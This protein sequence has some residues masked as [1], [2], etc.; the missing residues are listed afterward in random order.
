MHC[1]LYK[2]KKKLFLKIKNTAVWNRQKLY[3]QRF[4]RSQKY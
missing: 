2:K 3:T 1:V 4:Y